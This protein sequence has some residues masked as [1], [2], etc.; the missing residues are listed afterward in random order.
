MS[1]M[2]LY[3][4]PPTRSNR[5]LWAVRELGID[6]TEVAVN[7]FE[8]EQN[9]PEYKKINPLGIVPTLEVDGSAIGESAAIVAFLVD[10]NPEKGLAP[11][12]D[13]PGRGMYYHWLVFGPAELDHYLVTITQNTRFLP[14]ATRDLKAAANAQERF[15]MRAQVLSE[16]LWDQPYLLGDTFSAADISVGHSCAWAKMVEALGSHTVL[17]DYVKRLEARPAFQAVW[18]KEVQVF[19]DQHA[20]AADG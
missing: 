19:P 20:K 15:D 9:K 17:M 7:L 14:L 5:A 4:F 12:I 10:Q 11:A 6:L 8:G 16:R 2:T 13:D 3:H 1:G 18:G